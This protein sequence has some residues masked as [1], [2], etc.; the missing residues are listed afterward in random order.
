MAW[1]A[2]RAGLIGWWGP[3][4]VATLV[5]LHELLP[6]PPSAVDVVSMVILTVVF[7]YLGLRILRMTDIQWIGSHHGDIPTPAHA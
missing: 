1:A 3:A 7:G 2:W 6:D 5:L 4:V